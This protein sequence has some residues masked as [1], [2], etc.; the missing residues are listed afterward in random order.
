MMAHGLINE[1]R[2]ISRVGGEGKILERGMKQRYAPSI[3]I[4]IYNKMLHRLTDVLGMDP[5]I[6]TS[7]C[8]CNSNSN[9]FLITKILHT[10]V[11]VLTKITCACGTRV[12]RTHYTPTY[13]STT[14]QR[15]CL[16]LL[17]V[18]QVRGSGHMPH[19]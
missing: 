7:I 10:L 4:F 12:C 16:S 19:E 15:D 9:K 3:K 18:S 1:E 6:S 17:L 8:C 13:Y 14:T 11:N 5:V 2:I